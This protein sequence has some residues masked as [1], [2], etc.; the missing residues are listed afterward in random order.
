MQF[1]IFYRRTTSMFENDVM[2]FERWHDENV[3]K[4][5]LYLLLF[6][7]DLF[8]LLVSIA[9]LRLMVP[10]WTR[11]RKNSKIASLKIKFQ[12]IVLFIVDWPIVLY[13]FNIELSYQTR[14]IYSAGRQVF[15]SVA[16]SILHLNSKS[17]RT[18]KSM[19]KLARF[20]CEF[21]AVSLVSSPSSFSQL[22]NLN[23]NV[24]VILMLQRLK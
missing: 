2:Y 4:T 7:V 19:M 14:L 3:R 8:W 10:V 20:L 21:I 1:L 16:D 23:L 24:L 5:Y 22:L 6:F 9:S 13:V 18:K 12:D 17:K 15:F 11:K